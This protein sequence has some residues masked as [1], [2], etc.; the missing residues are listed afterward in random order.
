[1]ELAN[2]NISV[3]KFNFKDNIY[4]NIVISNKCDDI[5]VSNKHDLYRALG[6]NIA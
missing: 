2:V 5:V 4:Y 1:M 6:M 3:S